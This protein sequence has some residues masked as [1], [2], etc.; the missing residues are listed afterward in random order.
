MTLA[1]LQALEIGSRLMVLESDNR[2][3]KNERTEIK[4][5][6]YGIIGGVMVQLLLT[7][8]QLRKKPDA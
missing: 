1:Q 6:A 5:L 3:S 7:A 8:T 2:D 4:R